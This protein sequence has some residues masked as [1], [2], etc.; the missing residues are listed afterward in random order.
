MAQ[1]NTY[2]V[3]PFSVQ[4]PT[5]PQAL[6]HQY[7]PYHFDSQGLP[8]VTI[9][10]T[11]KSDGAPAHF[12][13]VGDAN[14]AFAHR[15]RVTEPPQLAPAQDPT[16]VKVRARRELYIGE[17]VQAVFNMDGIKDNPTFNGLPMFT[18]GHKSEVSGYD[19]E[20]AARLLFDA[21]LA[22]CE[23]G[24]RGP[25]KG[26][27]LLGGR[28]DVQVADR[29]GGCAARIA[30]IITALHDWKSV[31]RDIVLSDSKIYH[32]AN[33]P[34]SVAFDKKTQWH[35]NNTK[36]KNTE[37]DRAAATSAAQTDIAQSSSQTVTSGTQGAASNTIQP[38]DERRLPGRN[39]NFK[40]G[41]KGPR[42]QG[43]QPPPPLLQPSYDDPEEEQLPSMNKASFLKVP[44]S[45]PQDPQSHSWT[46]AQDF[47]TTPPAYGST[48]YGAFQQHAPSFRTQYY[49]LSNGAP[50]YNIPGPGVLQQA[51]QDPRGN[52][53]YEP[54]PTNHYLNYSYGPNA[55]YNFGDVSLAQHSPMWAT[56]NAF[57]DGVHA[58]AT[59]DGE[60]P[61]PFS[62]YQGTSAQ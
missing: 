42:V 24:Y 2:D 45:T 48:Y 60:G 58:T 37:N 17:L 32:L 33:A 59:G 22:R 14:G 38:P 25:V 12:A 19:V 11:Y 57:D 27:R 31:C 49:P 34:A 16:I 47:V 30:N 44:D 39:R 7:T 61:E 20:A 35:N 1:N 40:R 52:G 53:L 6:V 26:N 8:D 56:S 51:P 36:K 55:Q 28:K 23:T 4:P 54:A 9:P 21:V 62:T 10:Y 5:P 15:H 18:H 41:K 50:A 43:Q 3:P 46:A 29:D 13:W